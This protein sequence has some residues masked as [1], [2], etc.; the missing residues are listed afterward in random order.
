MNEDND[1]DAS[2]GLVDVENDCWQLLKQG[3]EVFAKFANLSTEFRS[4]A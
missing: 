4:I 2:I 1:R 3:R